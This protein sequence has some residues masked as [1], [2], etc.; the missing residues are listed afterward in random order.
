[1]A[2]KHPTIRATHPFYACWYNMLQ[3]CQNGRN[4]S[5]SSYGGRGI[6]VCDRWQEFQNFYD[7]M[8]DG[9]QKGLELERRDNN[10]GYSPE[11]CLWADRKTQCRN[12]SAT[13][14]KAEDVARIRE[15]AAKGAMQKTLATYYGVSR[16]HISRIVSGEKWDG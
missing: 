16:S 15:L 5:Y 7:D 1:M 4:V 2:R 6:T 13:K 3:R 10:A 8:F 12:T 9:W 11:N 14:L